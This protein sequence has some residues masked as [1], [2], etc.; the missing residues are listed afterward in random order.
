MRW[1]LVVVLVVV[2]IGLF[3]MRKKDKYEPRK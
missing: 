1:I 2:L 3:V